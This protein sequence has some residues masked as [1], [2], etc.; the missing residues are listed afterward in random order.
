MPDYI[1]AIDQGT[2]STRFI[3]FDRAG[4]IVASAQKEHRQI[5]PQS[6]WVEHD[7]RRDLEPHTGSDRRGHGAARPEALR[8][9]RHRHHQPAGNHGAVGPQDRAGGAQCA[10]LAGYAGGRGRIGLFARGRRRPFPRQDRPA[11]LHLFQQP[12]DPLASRERPRCSRAGDIL[13]GNIDTFPGLAP[14]RRAAHHRLHQRQPHPVDEPANARLGRRSAPRIR[15]PARDHAA[16]L[17][18]Q[19]TLRRSHAR[20]RFA[21]FPSPESWGISRPRWSARPASPPARPRTLTAPAVFC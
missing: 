17:L 19:R 8:P 5:Y 3:V 6:G 2:T 11:A 18:E 14:D 21:A 9:G 16:H 1:G 20:R 15:Y 13:F 4:R 12:E 10:G 7:P